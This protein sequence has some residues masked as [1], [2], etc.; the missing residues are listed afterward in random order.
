MK[1]KR[2]K[3]LDISVEEG[4]AYL[5]C[6]VRVDVPV[7]RVRDVTILGDCFEVMPL[8]PRGF[9]NLMIADPPYNLRKEYDGGVF[10]P[11]GAMIS[12]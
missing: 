5:R 3:T 9:V 10:A 6:C 12:R 4:T 1:S 2:N 8:L 11:I 7:T